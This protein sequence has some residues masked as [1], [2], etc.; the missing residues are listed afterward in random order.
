MAN[1]FDTDEES[2]VGDD[3]SY[4]GDTGVEYGSTTMDTGGNNESS[5]SY[6]GKQR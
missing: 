3:P 2:Y 6:Q 1:G 5:K 4:E